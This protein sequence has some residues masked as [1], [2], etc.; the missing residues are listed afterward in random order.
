MDLT[1]WFAP[2]LLPDDQGFDTAALLRDHASDL[3]GS[4]V[5]SGLTAAELQLVDACLHAVIWGYPLEETYR[6]RVLNTALQAPI[7]TLF[8]PSYAANW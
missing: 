2:Y 7:N 1:T 8:K 3:L 5:L 6:L 4:S